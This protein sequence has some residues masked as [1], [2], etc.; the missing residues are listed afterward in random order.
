MDI[1]QPAK[2]IRLPEE[3]RSAIE[4]AQ[5]KLTVANGEVARVSRLRAS[6]EAE[7]TNL[8]RRKSELLENIAQSESLI[9]QHTNAISVLEERY[10]E[11]TEEDKDFKKQKKEIEKLHNENLV[12]IENEKSDIREKR[13]RLDDLATTLHKREA[14]CEKREFRI[15]QRKKTLQ[16]ALNN[17]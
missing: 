6:I 5:N 12:E 11:L 2:E 4:N 8:T 13:L 3:I 15:D 17:I 16:D 14:E 7:I 10:S 1:N 9:L